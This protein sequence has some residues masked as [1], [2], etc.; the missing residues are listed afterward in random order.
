MAKRSSEAKGTQPPQRL[1]S[2]DRGSIGI[3]A[4]TEM[5]IFDDSTD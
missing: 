4:T 3:G 1:Q 5:C 2:I